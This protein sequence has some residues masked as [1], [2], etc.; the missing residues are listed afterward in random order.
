MGK[1]MVTRWTRGWLGPGVGR[2]G[3]KQKNLYSSTQFDPDSPTS[4]PH[5]GHFDVPSRHGDKTH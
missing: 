3:G 5:S 4:S 1:A 2:R